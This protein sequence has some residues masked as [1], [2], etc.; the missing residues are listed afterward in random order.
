MP[1]SVLYDMT[2][3]ARGPFDPF[4]V[5]LT[6]IGYFSLRF[7]ISLLR[8]DKIRAEGPD[9]FINRRGRKRS[10]IKDLLFSLLP[11][12]PISL[13]QA[14]PNLLR[15]LLDAY[16]RLCIGSPVV[17]FSCLVKRLTRYR[18]KSTNKGNASFKGAQ[19]VGSRRREERYHKK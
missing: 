19:C 10:E 17:A 11:D 18:V 1:L 4:F 13:R 8:R 5:V 12:R 7:V 16:L 15:L 14:I 2:S 9:L 6:Y 3:Y